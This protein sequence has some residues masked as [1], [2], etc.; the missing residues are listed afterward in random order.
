MAVYR[1]EDLLNEFATASTEVR[2]CETCH[3]LYTSI[4][5]CPCRDCFRESIKYTYWSKKENEDLKQTEMSD[6]KSGLVKEESDL[7]TNIGRLYD[8][9]QSRDFDNED[10][11]QKSL[12]LIQ[13]E[14]MRTYWRC[15]VARINAL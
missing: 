1:I 15:L 7:K 4:Y 12:S 11:T 8:F 14:A 6:F 2:N 10:E 9:T 13:L 3:H 5:V